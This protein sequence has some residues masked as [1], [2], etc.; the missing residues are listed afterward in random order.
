[1]NYV[2]WGKTSCP[3]AS[4]QLV[5]RGKIAGEHYTHPGGGVNYLCLPDSPR[6]SRYK[7]SYQSGGYVYGTEYELN[8]FNPFRRNLHN[9][10][11]PCAVCFV[12]SRSSV[13]MMPARNDCP[14]GWT[15]EYH[16]YLMAGKDDHSKSTDFIC[17]DENPEAVPGSRADMNGALLYPVEGHVCRSSPCSYVDGREL[18]CAVCTK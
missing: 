3:S 14:S 9:H 17:V 18:T 11:A 2:R 10:D 8:Y 7:D 15:K 6:Y 5:Y 4:A 12:S 1:V 16:G 13:L